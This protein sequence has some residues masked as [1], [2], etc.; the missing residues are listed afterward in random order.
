MPWSLNEDPRLG[1]RKKL[2]GRGEA[3]LETL[4]RGEPP[5]GRKCWT[6]QLLADRLVELKVVEGI[7]HETVRQVLKKGAQAMTRKPLPSK[8]GQPERFDYEYK[9]RAL[10]MD[11]GQRLLL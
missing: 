3:I 4:A 11:T 7:S 1:A 2:D 5:E 10:E 8:P 6:L 9:R